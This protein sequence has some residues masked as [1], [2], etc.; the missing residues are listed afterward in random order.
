MGVC[1]FFLKTGTNF[2]RTGGDYQTTS[3]DYDAPMNEYGFPSQPKYDHLMELHT[4]LRNYRE[5]LL[6]SQPNYINAGWGKEIHIFGTLDSDSKNLVVFSNYRDKNAGTFIFEDKTYFVPKWTVQFFTKDSDRDGLNLLYSTS[7][8]KAVA[9]LPKRDPKLSELRYKFSSIK[10]LPETIGIWDFSSAKGFNSFQEQLFLTK[11][12]SDYL[13]YSL[14]N[15]RLKINDLEPIILNLKSVTDVWYIWVDNVI[16][17]PNS[18][19]IPTSL[20]SPQE[21]SGK[22]YSI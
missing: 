3:Y 16:M 17:F 14:S 9:S 5:L 12:Q 15:V 20:G 13:W 19:S 18:I 22:I 6:Y 10:W 11:D 2:G 7:Q 8:T 4:V 21:I 1:I